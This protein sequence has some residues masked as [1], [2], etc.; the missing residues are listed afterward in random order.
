MRRPVFDLSVLVA[1][2]LL[3]AFLVWHGNYGERGYQYRE[4]VMARLADTRAARDEI[5]A[6]RLKLEADVSLLRPDAVDPDMIDE[7][8]RKTLGYVKENEIVVPLPAKTFP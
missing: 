4:L 3:L 5:R 2:L 6:K 7:L 1:T 8:S